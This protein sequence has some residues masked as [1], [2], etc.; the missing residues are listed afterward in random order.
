M[1]KALAD[2]GRR[3]LLDALR[4]GDGQSLGELCTVLPAMSRFGVMKHL[5]VLEQ[6]QLVVT[7]RVGRTKRHYL[8]PVPIR[9]L[10][11]RWISRFAEPLAVA[12]VGLRHAVEGTD[13]PTDQATDEESAG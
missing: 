5:T 9:E 13:Q 3:Q 11:E 8:N 2:R 12:M 1:F 4:D 7:Q 10:H 6:A